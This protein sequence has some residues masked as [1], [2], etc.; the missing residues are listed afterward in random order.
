MDDGNE[1]RLERT[2]QKVYLQFFFEDKR[3]Y[4]RYH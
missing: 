3:R 1:L 4:G 2:E